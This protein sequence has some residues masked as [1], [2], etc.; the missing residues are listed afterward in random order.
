MHGGISAGPV[1]GCSS[2]PRPLEAL[3]VVGHS[4]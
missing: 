4:I 2:E 1:D 3:F